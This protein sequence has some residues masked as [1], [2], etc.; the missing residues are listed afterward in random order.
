MYAA[1]PGMWV[2]TTLAVFNKSLSA[3]HSRSLVT[4]A[5]GPSQSSQA[6]N[7]GSAHQS[8]QV[9]WLSEPV[10]ADIIYRAFNA[11]LRGFSQ[12]MVMDMK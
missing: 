5:G 6:M 11:V 12:N 9:E 8:S 2:P 3:T 10:M 4:H 1:Y 7:S